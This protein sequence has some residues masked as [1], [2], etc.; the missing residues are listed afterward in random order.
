MYWRIIKGDLRRNKVISVVILLCVMAASAL[1]ALTVLLVA[2]TLGAVNALML[3]AE[4]PHYEW[5][6]KGD[7][8]MMRLETFGASNPNVDEYQVLEFL[9]IPGEDIA[10]NGQ[11]QE[12]SINDNGLS[13][14]SRLFDYLIDADGNIINVYDGEIYLPMDYIREGLAAVGDEVMICD[15]EFRVA[16]FARDSQMN[17][18]MSSSK[19]LLVSDSDFAAPA[20]LFGDEPTGAL[21]SKSADEIMDAFRQINDEGTAVVLVTHDA[22]VAARAK[23]VLFMKDGKIVREMLMD[24][25][26]QDDMDTRS[27]AIW[28]AANSIEI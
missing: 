3:Q 2:Q 25:Y 24:T 7:I 11:F 28:E 9:N 12:D 20:V 14:Q 23:R 18:S 21:N 4:T 10:I 26:P 15:R 8:D 22:K 5:M 17:S 16:G 13:T 27:A 6:H 19:R 1:I